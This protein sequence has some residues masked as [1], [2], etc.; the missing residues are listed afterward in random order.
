[1]GTG[2]TEAGEAEAKATRKAARKAVRKAERKTNTDDADPQAKRA[3]HDSEPATSER[4][5]PSV[6]S[7]V[8][9]KSANDDERAAG[10]AYLVKH[11]ITIHEEGAPLPCLTLASAPFPAVVVKLLCLQPN[12][13]EPSPVQAATWPVA[14]A[15]RDVLAIAKTGSGKTLGF[16]LPV[17]AKC[18]LEKAAAD[19]LPMALIMAPTRELALQIAAEALKFG[20]SVGCRTVAVYGG[21]P[22]GPQISAIQKGCELII[23]T[24]GRISDVIDVRGGGRNSCTS[25]L[26][27]SML[28]LD[29]ADRMLDMGFERDIRSIVWEAFGDRA[30]QTF[31]YSATWPVAVQQIADDMLTNSIKITVGAGGDKLTANSSVK[32]LVHVIEPFERWETFCKLMSAF[33]K[34]GADSSKRV[35]VFANMKSTVN[36]I[37]EYCRRQGLA[38]D[39]MSGD[40]SQSQRET[41]LRKVRLCVCVCV[42]VCVCMCVCVRVLFIGT[43][44]VTCVCVCVCVCVLVLVL[45]HLFADTF[46]AL[47]HIV[48][49]RQHQGGDRYRCSCART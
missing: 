22:K 20:K 37:T 5:T 38:A 16:L 39:A 24:P 47:V 44:S 3:K 49:G 19:G 12:F 6:Q 46:C 41:T 29:E 43:P 48:P 2:K 30:H 14:T 23:G 45:V 27:M 35:I 13:A 4:T 34:G 36:K 42:C 28:V 31:L 7:E 40:R 10:Q 18:L 33:R 25:M 8:A 11:H 21:A 9:G 15:G 17:L 1:M 32:Q 26:R